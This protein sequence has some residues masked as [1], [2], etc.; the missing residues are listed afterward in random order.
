M[1]KTINKV[2]LT[3]YAGSAPEI[4]EF[5]NGGTIARLSIATRDFFK[6]KEGEWV[7]ETTW[8]RIVF[9]NKA[10]IEV[11]EAVSK[12]TRLNIKGKLSNR[13][14]NDDNGIKHF[15]TEVIATEF[16][17]EVRESQAEDLVKEPDFVFAEETTEEVKPK[18]KRNKKSNQ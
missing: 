18:A 1:E 8:H 2:E 5:E 16:Q 15:I 13:S 17:I 12:G 11:S 10:A 4:K 6:N 7:S 9:R 14:W 3:G